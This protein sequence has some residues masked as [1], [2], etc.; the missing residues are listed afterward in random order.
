MR[1]VDLRALVMP[2]RVRNE[3]FR[4]L[5][6]IE[7]AETAQALSVSEK[8]AEGFVLGLETACAFN[9]E[10]IETFYIGFESAAKA[11]RFTLGTL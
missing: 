3:V 5:A 1:K 2:T 7:V 11:R 10:M 9:A 8:R 6:A 4:L